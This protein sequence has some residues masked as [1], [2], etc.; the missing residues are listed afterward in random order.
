MAG[1]VEGVGLEALVEGSPEAEVEGVGLEALVAGTSIAQVQAVG[2]EV[3][4]QV[5]P[6][7]IHRRGWG[8]LLN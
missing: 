2:L 7:T 1:Q 5:L 3:L 4:V 8:I 6:T